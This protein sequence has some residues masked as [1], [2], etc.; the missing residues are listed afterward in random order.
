M[1]H[2]YDRE[3]I[4]QQKELEK[5][6][7][8][9]NISFEMI[10]DIFINFVVSEIFSNQTPHFLKISNQNKN[11]FLYLLDTAKKGATKEITLENLDVSRFLA[12]KSFDKA[13]DGS[14]EKTLA[15][16][17][18]CVLYDRESAEFDEFGPDPLIEI[19]FS[20]LLKLGDGYCT[21]FVNF[22]RNHEYT[23]MNM[24]ELLKLLLNKNIQ[25]SQTN[26]TECNDYL[27]SIL[28]DPTCRTID[29]TNEFDVH[30]VLGTTAIQINTAHRANKKN[31]GFDELLNS[32]KKL[33]PNEKVV[34][35]TI[36]STEWSGRCVLNHK[37][38]KLIGCAFV[39]SNKMPA[40][41]TPPNWDGSQEMLIEYNNN[42]PN[43]NS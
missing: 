13:D 41:R 33:D 20:C 6:L 4:Y 31:F 7:D 19:L 16:I 10:I 1:I 9:K 32:L 34:W 21:K 36:L 23:K 17:L 37:K 26:Q 38:T 11:L 25:D 28:N 35:V 27:K 24:I 12:W 22:I 42:H 2:I 5:F 3:D 15:R 18:V 14:V 29:G 39:E 43:L 30:Y 8:T 40:L